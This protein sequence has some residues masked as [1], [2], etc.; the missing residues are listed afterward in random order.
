[1]DFQKL[2]TLK[3]KLD[4]NI[5]DLST[6]NTRS[7]Y[8]RTLSPKVFNTEIP[9]LTLHN[10]NNESILK[11]IYS[12]YFSRK[13]TKVKINLKSSSNKIKKII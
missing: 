8:D 4:S 9:D 5:T 2:S 7:Q 11:D 1:M 3:K 10:F 12:S 13:K 6:I